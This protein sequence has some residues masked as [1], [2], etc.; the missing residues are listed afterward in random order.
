[1]P[2]YRT[3]V[4]VTNANTAP[5]PRP[6]LPAG[7]E[8]GTAT[9]VAAAAVAVVARDGFDV[10]SVRTV[11]RE[12]GV[13]AGTVQHHYP[14]R[15]LLL[16]AAFAQ[17]VRTIT[18]R[19]TVADRSGTFPVVLGQLCREVLPLDPQRRREGIVWVTLSA[20][21]ANHPELAAEHR[22]AVRALLDALTEWIAD[23]R[24]AGQVDP[25]VDP[26]S[27]AA[28][29][30]AVLDGLTLHGIV[31]SQPPSTLTATLDRAISLV[32]AQP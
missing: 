9:R 23:V 27:A 22:T 12:A 11:A 15:T 6:G 20:A 30:V 29:L 10:L 24:M 5:K 19:L 32:L 21:A 18:D 8:T 1:M 7:S 17:T 4:W 25:S 28:M 16:L 13:S 26:P 14:T 2:P 31:G 3:L